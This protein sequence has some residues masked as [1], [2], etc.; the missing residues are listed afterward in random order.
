MNARALKPSISTEGAFGDGELSE[1]VMR[2]KGGDRAAHLAFR[3]VLSAVTPL[4]RTQMRRL[5]IPK[6]AR[7]DGLQVG[8]FA[9]Y[10]ATVQYDFR[11]PFMAFVPVHTW[12][13]L[14]VFAVRE[15]GV[16]H[17][18]LGAARGR[19]K[20]GRALLSVVSSDAPREVVAPHGEHA[21]YDGAFEGED[22]RLVTQDL[23][24]PADEQYIAAE[25]TS[26]VRRALSRLPPK[27]R[28]V[29]TR[30]FGFGCRAASVRDLSY[31]W[32]VSKHTVGVVERRALRLMKALLREVKR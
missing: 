29:L 10:R 30:L 5:K 20:S 12:G 21:P 16:V 13:A 24:V 3:R 1:L 23:A 15:R 2:S 25:E 32:R 4:I 28:A 26:A 11:C 7:E 6:P 19:T 14:S 31:E 8:A 18:S 22:W 9:V 17:V 27:P